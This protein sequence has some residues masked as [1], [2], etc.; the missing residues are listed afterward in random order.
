MSRLLSITAVSV[1]C[2]LC[3]ACGKRDRSGA[4]EEEWSDIQAMGD[5]A[6][7]VLVEPAPARDEAYP[8]DPSATDS[9]FDPYI[10]R[11]EQM[12]SAAREAGETL[13]SGHSLVFD[14]ARQTVRMD[15][16][17][18]V[19]DDQGTLESEHLATQ[20]SSGSR[21]RSVQ[22]GG[23]VTVRNADRVARADEAVYDFESGALKL[24]GRAE[25]S[26]RGNRISGEQILFWSKGDRRVICE[27]N[28][29]FLIT[30]V[31]EFDALRKARP[32]ETEIRA[33]RVVFDEAEGVAD[34]EGH[35]RLR[36]ADVAMDCGRVRVYLKEAREI[37]W[38]EALDE[39]IIRSG[40]SDG[41]RAVADKAVYWVDE[42]KFILE[43]RPMVQSG[44]NIMT[45]DRISV[46][47]ET[48]QMIC[49]PNARVLLY[50]DE[51]S[52]AKFMKD[53]DD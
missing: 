46:W 21:V 30:D 53:L 39:V 24:Q 29:L 34:L 43:G 28:A 4:A 22:A 31:S 27:P 13:F 16:G 38:I 19:T 7:V 9:G 25:V 5:D 51:E 10:R 8:S 12:K 14:Y 32:G 45:G 11:L 15:Q 33:D 18:V 2:L 52:R 40:E 50:L 20:F 26:R 41:M 6:A 37:S 42:G 49:E 3:S 47:H 44:V 23:G 36:D 1:L 48:Q 35:V 17:V